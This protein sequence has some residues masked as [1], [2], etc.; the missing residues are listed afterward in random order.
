MP[1]PRMQSPVGIRNIPLSYRHEDSDASALRLI[2]HL[3]PE[4]ETSEGE[5]KLIRFTDGITNTVCSRDFAPLVKDSRVDSIR[6]APQGREET[7]GSIPARD[8]SGC[9]PHESV[10]RGN[11]C[12]DRPRAYVPILF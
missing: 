10:R 5:V 11:G 9:D 2:Y 1:V 12:V 4:W 7:S 8:R 6:V 3:A